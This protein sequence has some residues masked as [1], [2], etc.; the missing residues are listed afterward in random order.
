MLLALGLR[1]AT[2]VPQRN[3]NTVT[4]NVPGPA[5][6][7]LRGRPADARVLPLRAAGRPRPRR[8]SRSSPTT[9]GSTSA[10]PATTT[11]A[12]GH[13]RALRGDRALD[14][15]SCWRQRKPRMDRRRAAAPRRQRRHATDG[16]R[17]S[18]RPVRDQDSVRAHD[19]PA[20]GR[21]RRERHRFPEARPSG[22]PATST[23]RSSEELDPSGVFPPLPRAPGPIAPGPAHRS[24]L[25]GR[26]RARR[27]RWSASGARSRRRASSR[28]A[29]RPAPAAR[30]GAR[31]GRPG[32]TPRRW[33]T[34]RSR[35]GPRTTSTSS[36]RG[37]ALRALGAARLHRAGQGRG[38][39]AAVRRALRAR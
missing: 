18:P 26:W 21:S 1:A 25:V 9:A 32:M 8:A 29:D 30:S 36:G 33:P 28:R 20:R 31:C 4:T 19:Q 6:P 14:G 13:R 11:Q 5:A 12:P 3:V 24:G 39:R 23:R 2:R 38:D 15:A 16:S 7:A 22:A 34:S 37:P 17:R 35:G 27:S 10:S